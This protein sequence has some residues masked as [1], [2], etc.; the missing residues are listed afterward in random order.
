VRA[1]LVKDWK[2]TGPTPLAKA[3]CWKTGLSDEWRFPPLQGGSH[4]HAIAKARA[5]WAEA[6]QLPLPRRL[7]LMTPSLPSY[8][9]EEWEWLD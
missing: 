7:L 9:D 2:L 6:G 1:K 4:H 3:S 5:G 8:D